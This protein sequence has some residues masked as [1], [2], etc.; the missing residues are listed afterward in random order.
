MLNA[1]FEALSFADIGTLAL[2]AWAAN[3]FAALL[4]AIAGMLKAP[5]EYRFS[6]LRATY[7]W[8]SLMFSDAWKAYNKVAN[9]PVKS[10]A[11]FIG[12]GI[13]LGLGHFGFGTMLEAVGLSALCAISFTGV[14]HLTLLNCAAPYR[15]ANHRAK[16]V[17][18][19]IESRA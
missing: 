19:Y 11:W 6:A 4:Y 12:T 2:V 1:F 14:A 17:Q 10:C 16:K 3:E 18:D 7:L 5:A 13:F 9:V 8:R 15:T